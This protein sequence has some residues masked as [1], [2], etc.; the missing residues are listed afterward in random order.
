[1]EASSFS[2]RV[3]RMGAILREGAAGQISD[4][5]RKFSSTKRL[6]EDFLQ[7]LIVQGFSHDQAYETARKF[8]GSPVVKFAAVDGTEYTKRLFDLVIFFG[9]AYTA[10]GEIEFKKGVK[11]SVTY[12][13]ELLEEGCGISSCV[14]VYINVVPEIDQ[15]FFREEEPGELSLSRPLADQEIVDNSKIANWIMTFSEYFLAYKLATDSEENIKILLLDRA[16]SGEVSSIVYDTAKRS[17][18]STNCAILGYEVDGTPIDENDLFF[19]RHRVLNSELGLPPARGDYLRHSILFSLEQEENPLALSE[20]LD[21]LGLEDEKR[22]ERAE[23]YLKGLV[24]E[25]LISDMSGR[26]S[27][28]PRYRDTWRRL[29]TLVETLGDQLFLEDDEATEGFVGSKMTI[30]KGGKQHYLTTLDIAFLTLF[31]LY[32]LLEECWKRRV[33]LVG[34]TKDTSARDFKR[35]VVPIFQRKGLLNI[36]L[37]PE[38]FDKVPNTDRML[39]QSVSLFNHEEISLPWSLV[40]Y[41]SAFVTMVPDHERDP[42]HVRGARRNRIRLERLFLKSYIQL[43]QANYDPKL[44]SNVLLMDRLVYPEYDLKEENRLR[45]VH[46]YAGVEEP[47]EVIFYKNK[48][49]V[50]EV[51]NLVM[52]TLEAMTSP[53]IPEAFGHNKP[54]FVADKVAKW[55][56]RMI[57]GV[58]DATRHWIMTNRDLRDFVFYMTTF[59]ERRARLERLRRE[60]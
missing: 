20:I 6:F 12:S 47:L 56:N 37:I 40:E 13:N 59:R 10:K 38:E 26:Y 9:G 24:K 42:D 34:L 53:S 41:D 3:R 60:T 32:M 28:A 14:P 11:P 30:E 27:L 1:M 36:S 50:N 2:S 8:F 29:R 51:Q 31:C 25:G 35:H 58:I 55:N 4:Y 16:I 5:R 44:R 48:D 18:W 23:R 15:T 54:L 52:V 39:L 7:K 21:R 46:H 19:G 45:F 17:Y 57:R 43:S 33:L 49:M 22:R